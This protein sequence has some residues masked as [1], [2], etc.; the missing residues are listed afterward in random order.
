[1]IHMQE[2]PL[3]TYKNVTGS[4]RDLCYDCPPDELPHRAVY[5]SVRGISQLCFS[6]RASTDLNN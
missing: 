4:D 5:V 2:C 1:M 6:L 3:G